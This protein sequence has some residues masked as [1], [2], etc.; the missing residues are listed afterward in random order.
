MNYQ[1]IPRVSGERIPQLHRGAVELEGKGM[2]RARFIRCALLG[3]GAMLGGLS[4]GSAAPS[5]HASAVETLYFEAESMVL[6]DGGSVRAADTRTASGQ[7]LRFAGIS[8]ATKYGANVSGDS[9]Q[10]SVRARARKGNQWPRMQVKIDGSVVL[11]RK[12]RSV[13]YSQYQAPISV[14]AGPHEITIAAVGGMGGPATLYADSVRMAGQSTE[15]PFSADAPS[16]GVYNERMYNPPH[17]AG[18][19]VA[20][21][22]L[23][24]YPKVAMWYPNAAEQWPFPTQACNY[25]VSRGA[26]PHLTWE[27][28]GYSY[29]AIANG[30]H[31]SYIR[32][33]ARGAAQFGKPVLL[34]VFH[35]M[36]GDW[37]SWNLGQGA[38]AHKAAW[39]RIVTLFREEGASNVR[40]FWCPNEGGTY[41][42][43]LS[44]AWPGDDYVDIVGVDGYNWGTTYGAWRSAAQIIRP[45]YELLTSWSTRPFAVGET[46]SREAGGDKAAWIREAFLSD[47]GLRSFPR[48]VHV[49]VFD[50]NFGGYSDWRVNSSPEALRAYRSVLANLQGSLLS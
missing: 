7:A 14:T 23:G 44:A 47:S 11:D 30:N 38:S 19:D 40:F 36:N 3:T 6:G 20:D 13:S 17:I 46:N 45:K 4:I 34:R 15:E 18:I 27:F 21:N 22:L 12:V 39:R 31:D 1:G 48:L 28:F 26:L 29:T 25:S 41:D 42:R 8:S 5:A 33:F 37:Y 9:V 50:A 24:H 16:L 32:Q 35:E 10:I 49:T 43:Q 2:S